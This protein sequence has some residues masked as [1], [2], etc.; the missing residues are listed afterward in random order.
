MLKSDTVNPNSPVSLLNVVDSTNSPLVKP[1]NAKGGTKANKGSTATENAVHLNAWA[2]KALE[3]N[4]ESLAAKAIVKAQCA[5]AVAE[6]YK[7]VEDTSQDTKSGLDA[8]EVV[9]DAKQNV[10]RAF[11]SAI[12]AN[13]FDRSEAR[14]QLG[15]S[16]GFE[17][18]PKTGKPTSKPVEPGNTI[19]KRVS[20]VTI[21]AEYAMTGQLPDRGGESLPLVG[22]NEVADLLSDYFDGSITVRA[23]SER[24]EK[25]IRDARVSI[26][27][28]MDAEKVIRLAGKIET[29]ANT[30]ANDPELRAA[31][32]ALFQIV[33]SIPFP[34]QMDEAA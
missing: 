24:I 25:A 8:A 1:E 23:A 2:A 10:A 11:A 17:V 21:A 20:S 15:T 14:N 26:P 33:A 7:A 31:Y 30:I 22:Q 32:V 34:E 18:S 3:A 19:A 4:S 6:Y 16:F 28:E 9:E 12:L 5:E 29:A 27:L 13:V